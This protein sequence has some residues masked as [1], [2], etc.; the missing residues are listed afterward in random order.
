[1]SSS[2]FKHWDA[3]QKTDTNS[4]ELALDEMTSPLIKNWKEE[5]LLI[6]IL[7]IEGFP[8]NSKIKIDTT[9]DSNKIVLVFEDFSD[10]KLLICLDEKI[11]SNT[12]SKMKVIQ[13]GNFIC[14][15]TA[16]NDSQKIELSNKIII[17]T[18]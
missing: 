9:F 16:I 18:I 7:L 17:K 3:F 8:I 11:N 1:M 15:D 13:N 14:L 4:L 2:N 10:Y 12:I 6:E 5:D